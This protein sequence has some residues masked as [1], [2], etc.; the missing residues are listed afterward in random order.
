MGTGVLKLPRIELC[1]FKVTSAETRAQAIRHL[2]GQI[3]KWW[4]ENSKPVTNSILMNKLMYYCEKEIQKKNRLFRIDTGWYL[5]G[6][7]YEDGRRHE[8]YDSAITITPVSEEYCDEIDNVCKE[9]VP[10]FNDCMKR[11]TVMTEFLEYI[12]STKCDVQELKDYYLAKHH[13]ITHF[14]PFGDHSSDIRTKP[15]EEILDTIFEFEGAISS[16]E[17]VS[18]IDIDKEKIDQVLD[19]TGLVAEYIELDYHEG[20]SP[21]FF[22]LLYELCSRILHGFGHL[23]YSSSFYSYNGNHQ[24]NVR[25]THRELADEFFDSLHISI[26]NVY[27]I[28][29]KSRYKVTEIV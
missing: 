14:K 9:L 4:E 25:R 26:S 23:N 19:L 5:Y 1:D 13:F 27:D 29:S 11:G 17:Y 16:D 21:A 6:P 28:Y 3:N 24:S 7:C 18:E 10:R 12:Y 2:Y 15:Q 8:R 20:A 22:S